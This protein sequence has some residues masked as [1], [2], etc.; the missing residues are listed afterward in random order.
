MSPMRGLLTRLTRFWAVRS[1]AVGGVAT[2]LDLAIVVSGVELLALPRVPCVV[3]GVAV[4]GSV[5][6]LLN[7]YFA[8]ND[9]G[10][11]VGFQAFKYA[12]LMVAEIGIHTVLVAT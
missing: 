9:R 12:A 3:A 8:F 7:K 11:P 6:F 2:V 10:R 1:L 5:S 4:G